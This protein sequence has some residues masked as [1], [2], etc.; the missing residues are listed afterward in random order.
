MGFPP[1]FLGRMALAAK[2]EPLEGWRG[3]AREPPPPGPPPPASSGS[4]SL[5]PKVMLR[6]AEP[7]ASDSKAPSRSPGGLL[8]SGGDCCGCVGGK[9]G[10]GKAADGD[11]GGK[12]PDERRSVAEERKSNRP[13][14]ADRTSQRSRA[15][16]KQQAGQQPTRSRLS[17]KGHLAVHRMSKET[18]AATQAL[19]E[20]HNK[21]MGRQELRQV[22]GEAMDDDIFE[23]IF[24]LFDS[25]GGGTVNA[26][27]F[28]TTM[29]LITGD[30]CQTPEQQAEAGSSRAPGAPSPSRR[31]R[32]SSPTW[33]VE[34]VFVMFDV[35]DGGSLSPDEFR[36]LIKA[37]VSLNLSA[38]LG[39]DVGK[40]RRGRSVASHPPSRRTRSSDSASI[41]HRA[42]PPQVR[43]APRARVL[44]REPRLLQGGRHV[45]DPSTSEARI[46]QASARLAR[47]HASLPRGRAQVRPDGRRRGARPARGGDRRRVCARGCAAAG[48]PSRDG[49]EAHPRCA[50]QPH[51]SGGRAAAHAVR[52]TLEPPCVASVHHAADVVTGTT[53]RAKRYSSSWRWTPL[54]DSRRR[55]RHP[56]PRSRPACPPAHAS[57]IPRCR[58]LAQ[59]DVEA[60]DTL[61]S[62]FYASTDATPGGAVTLAGFREWALRNTQIFIFFSKLQ[63]A[64]R[65]LLD[66]SKSSLRTSQSFESL[67]DGTMADAPEAVE[68]ALKGCAVEAEQSWLEAMGEGV[69][70][71]ASRVR[72]WSSEAFGGEGE[73]PAAAAPAA[74][75]SA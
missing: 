63:A 50:G 62:E 36:G 9:A 6:E 28:G 38:L 41:N 5:A 3:W 46:T 68:V 49:A 35:D 4:G 43:G 57:F 22:L 13:V 37:T 23:A 74:L 34:A 52:H 58:A 27:E 71:L 56:S 54:R 66:N 47:A 21:E 7:G 61:V 26:E 8:R 72:S 24:H 31:C 25:D 59:D 30:E 42:V 20:G 70:E 75:P 29:A 64:A 73:A 60:V 45:C 69:A 32:D 11:A 51:R 14:A 19:L 17:V 53:R 39:T 67:R 55:R 1:N 40:R 2:D 12:P 65:R 10:G 33:Q 18:L 16:L 48:E 44:G 15:V